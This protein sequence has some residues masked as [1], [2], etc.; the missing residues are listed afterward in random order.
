MKFFFI[1]AIGLLGTIIY[2]VSFQC[3]D[4]KK[5]FKYQ[6]LSYVF[7]VIH[8]LLLNAYT[9]CLSYLINAFRSYCLSSKHSI[10]K[11]KYIC[12]FICFLQL[13]VAFIT[14]QNIISLLVPLANIASTIVGYTNDFKKIRLIGILFNSPLWIIYNISVG[15]FAGVI[16][17]IISEISMIIS[18]IRFRF[19]ENV[20]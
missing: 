8:M 17:E 14:Y 20:E 16:D 7:Y 3:R 19:K 11:S 18:L 1:Q 9:G 13:T 15:S 6:L 10:L 4:N 5:L 12:I 2:F